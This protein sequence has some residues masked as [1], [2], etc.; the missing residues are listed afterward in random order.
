MTTLQTAR[1]IRAD[2]SNLVATGLE[3]YTGENALF[4]AGADK[5]IWDLKPQLRPITN[6][7]GFTHME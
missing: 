7:D 2:R 5:G 6:E 3:N 4:D 1:E